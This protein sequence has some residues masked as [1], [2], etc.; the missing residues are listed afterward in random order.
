MHKLFADTPV[1]GECQIVSG[2]DHTYGIRYM[3][4]ATLVCCRVIINGHIIRKIMI[5]CID[6]T[7]VRY[8]NRSVGI[9]RRKN[10]VS[11]VGNYDIWSVC[12]SGDQSL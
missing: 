7:V 4:R 11:S 12:L 3:F 2:I 6:L 9:C 8:R 10:L 1:Q 5:I